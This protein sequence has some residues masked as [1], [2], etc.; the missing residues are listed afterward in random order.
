MMMSTMGKTESRKNGKKNE[1]WL[2]LHPIERIQLPHE[3]KII[4]NHA[5]LGSMSCV[6]ERVC[7]CVCVCLCE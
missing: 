6:C 7:A 2:T 3:Y 4:C 5:R 1:C